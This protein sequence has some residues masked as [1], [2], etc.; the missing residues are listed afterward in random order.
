MWWCC[1]CW[2]CGGGDAPFIIALLPQ[3]EIRFDLVS[4][5]DELA[6]Q[7]GGVRAV[8][9][10]QCTWVSLFP[11]AG[12]WQAAR[13]GGAPPCGPCPAPTRCALPPPHLLNR[14]TSSLTSGGR[15]ALHRTCIA[16][17]D[18]HHTHERR[19]ASSST[20]EGRR[21]SWTR[22]PAS[23]RWEAGVRRPRRGLRLRTWLCWSRE[24][25]PAGASCVPGSACTP[26]QRASSA[27]TDLP[28]HLPSLAPP[29][30]RS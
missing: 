8:A 5:V 14:S 4:A 9:G 10:V 20:S 19:S 1:W 6:S 30:R 22:W 7:V 21:A 16:P 24:G 13:R 28:V 11:A 3:T 15:R 25:V 27:R 17:H 18:P 12:P 2:C 29:A 26:G 23:S